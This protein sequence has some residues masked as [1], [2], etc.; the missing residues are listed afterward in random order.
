MYP[1]YPNGTHRLLLSASAVA[2]LL[3][4][5]TAAAQEEIS[6]DVITVTPNTTPTEAR[7]VGSAVSVVTRA[8]LQERQT[9][10]VAD[11]LR[12]LPGVTLDRSGT[13]GNITQVR[14][15]GTEPNQT[16]VLIDGVEMNDPSADD[17]YDFG[18][19]LAAQ[20]ERI[21]VLKGPQSALYGS[22]AVGG[23]INIITRR[24]DG[25]PSVTGEIEG[26]SFGTVS[27]NAAVSGGNESFDFLVGGGGMRTDG[28]STAAEW[29]GNT[30]EDGYENGTAFAKFGAR[31]TEW[32]SLDLVGRF[33]DF[34]SEYDGFDYTGPL[35]IAVD[36]DNVQDGEQAFGR[37]QATVTL[38]DG[39]WQ[40]IFGATGTRHDRD[41]EF[42]SDNPLSPLKG[43]SRYVGEKSKLDYQS[44][45][46]LETGGPLPAS[47][48]LTFKAE[49]EEQSLD[50]TYYDP[51]FGGVATGTEASIESQGY[52]GQYQLDVAEAL[53]VTA[54]VR[55]DENDFFDDAT[56]YRTTAAYLFDTGTKVRA[57]YGTGVKN[58]TL[59]ELYGY[60]GTFT[61][62]PDL[63]PEE[64]KGWDVG[65]EQGFWDGRITAEATYFEER[66]TDL[67]AGAG[68]TA[69]NVPGESEI[70]GVELALSVMPVAGLTVTGS[71][72]HM[73]AEDANGDELIRRPEDT[74]S[75]HVNYA[76]L[77]GR[78][79]VN[80]GVSYVGER[81]DTA[82]DALFTAIPVTLEEYTLVDV[83]AS[84]KLTENAEIYG[85]VENLFDEQYEEVFSY[86]TPGRAAYAGLRVNF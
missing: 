20:V 37:A 57:S 38:F 77:E 76:F 45:V 49:H 85:R 4:H 86:G 63:Q 17:A 65:I 70:D 69:I 2:L 78:A 27:G 32:L 14:L 43:T 80:V 7:S 53:F 59:F 62:N 33:V 23:V 52:V 50:Y 6:L 12:T 8:E 18:H 47:H 66:I 35:G 11:A 41:Y 21:E 74:A 10:T 55:H 46:F 24:G 9:R 29:N 30:E 31:P 44:N 79:N 39:R 16:L 68:P 58:P 25:E 61:G 73:Q 19:L 34:E 54:A 84:Y 75:L 26:G 64:A 1:V 71:Y 60:T 15:R 22:D 5:G 82:F 81:Q 40:Q 28:V 51:G 3:A 48:T 13:F 56:T 72:T 67:I 83:A 36:A 42:E